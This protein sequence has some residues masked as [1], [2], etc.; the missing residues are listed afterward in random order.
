MRHPMSITL[1]YLQALN[2]TNSSRAVHLRTALP[3][4]QQELHRVTHYATQKLVPYPR[5]NDS[6]SFGGAQGV[7]YKANV[8]SGLYGTR[9][10][11][12]KEIHLSGDKE[13]KR[14]ENEIR[15]LRK[16][17]HP[18]VLKLHEVFT[19]EGDKWANIYSLVTEPWAETSFE[20]FF[21][22]LGSSKTGMSTLYPWHDPERLLPWPSIVK[23]CLLG[24]Q[25]L[26]T[27]SIKHK[28][29]KPANILLL[30]ESNGEAEY[31]RVRV[32]IADLGISKASTIGAPTSFV[33]TELY[34]APEQLA[35]ESSSTKS[36]IFSLGACFAIIQAVLCTKVG[37]VA[38]MRANQNQEGFFAIDKIAK[39]GFT[40]N[41]DQILA[42]LE[43]MQQD[44]EAQSDPAGS[45]FRSILQ[46][47]V[48][49]MFTVDPVKRPT[50]DELCQL[51]EGCEWESWR[52]KAS[53]HLVQRIPQISPKWN[54]RL[55]KSFNAESL[56]R[57]AGIKI[58]WTDVLADHLLLNEDDSTLHL[59]RA[60]P[61]L[62]ADQDIGDTQD[63]IFF[64]ERGQ[65][66]GSETFIS[67]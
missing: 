42:L 50:A 51:L 15:H 34:M 48:R 28:D 6:P 22:H 47:M 4:Q 27:N 5:D 8:P 46:R 23:Q 9:A 37:K 44:R 25:H 62:K 40:P 13:Q 14:L 49:K 53:N 41:I 52:E 39:G 64:L 66:L 7:V 61:L 63:E 59:F 17:D 18:N 20:R 32:I 43:Q 57:I 10:F 12:V 29:L 11:A 36:D 38:W 33:G 58:R 21:A 30:D 56:Q 1:L 45:L 2:I 24:L 31:P 60:A 16:C 3:S 67:Y 55:E 19:V 26:H 65:A 35:K 54:I